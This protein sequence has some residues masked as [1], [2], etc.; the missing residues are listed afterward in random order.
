[1]PY[2]QLNTAF[3]DSEKGNSPRMLAF[4]L[5]AL[6]GNFIPT[7]GRLALLRQAIAKV[8]IITGLMTNEG[9]SSIPLD[10]RTWADEREH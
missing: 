6:D 7:Y 5:K 9:S 3:V 2:E 1:M 8:P 10:V 4:A